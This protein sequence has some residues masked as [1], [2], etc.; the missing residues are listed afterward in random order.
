[1]HCGFCK[2][3][4]RISLDKISDQA[5]IASIGN[6]GSILQRL[7]ILL[8]DLDVQLNFLPLNLFLLKVQPCALRVIAKQ[9]I[10][11]P[12]GLPLLHCNFLHFLCIREIDILLSF[13]GD[14]ARHAVLPVQINSVIE[15]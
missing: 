13:R 10:A 9:H 14:P 1:M 8:G 2:Y 7:D 3:F 4:R 11:L 5:E 6:R 12:D 15:V